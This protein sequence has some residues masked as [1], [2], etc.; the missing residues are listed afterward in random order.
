MSDYS[1]TDHIASYDLYGT[2]DLISKDLSILRVVI[3]LF[4]FLDSLSN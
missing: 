2:T 1:I 4:Q 3:C